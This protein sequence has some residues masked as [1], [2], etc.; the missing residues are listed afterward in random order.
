MNRTGSRP[1]PAKPGSGEPLASQ[2]PG[3]AHSVS[4][5]WHQPNHP[6]PQ[7][8]SLCPSLPLT[9]ADLPS[10]TPLKPVTYPTVPSPVCRRQP[11]SLLQAARTCPASSATQGD[12][13][14]Q[15]PPC[16][17]DPR[18]PPKKRGADGCPSWHSFVSLMS[19]WQKGPYLGKALAS[20]KDLKP[21]F[22]GVCP[23]PLSP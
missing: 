7:P 21:P 6:E 18:P 12:H 16:A 23:V 10:P 17:H 22:V 1:I 3:T 19:V 9:A 5:A 8:P 11:R 20:P 2:A 4:V 14:V 15:G 13:K